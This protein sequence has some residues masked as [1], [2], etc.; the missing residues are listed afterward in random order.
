MFKIAIKR[1]FN[2]EMIHAVVRA[3]AQAIKALKEYMHCRR[4]IGIG[5][6]GSVILHSRGRGW[7]RL[8]CSASMDQIR[9]IE[10]AVK[11]MRRFWQDEERKTE[12]QIKMLSPL[13]HDPNLRVAAFSNAH[14]AGEFQYIG[15]STQD[16]QKPAPHRLAQLANKFNS[17]HNTRR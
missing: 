8:E 13:M 17:V 1:H 9:K 11:V 7:Y 10:F 5:F 12:E 3:D 4:D 6:P 14:S 15:R 16:Q 2:A